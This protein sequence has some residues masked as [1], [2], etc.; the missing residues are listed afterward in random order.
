MN[1]GRCTLTIILITTFCPVT[2][3][4]ADPQSKPTDDRPV[5]RVATAEEFVQ[6]LGPERVIL[7]QP[8]E[9]NLSKV[10]RAK[11][12]HVRWTSPID[13][14]YQVE[15]RNVPGL[16]IRG[17]GQEPTHVFVHDPYAFV[18]TFRN[19]PRL[20]L[21]NLRMGHSPDAG[22]C[23]GGVVQ[24]L[25]TE[26]VRIGQCSLYGSGTEGLHLERVKALTFARSVIEDCTYGILTADDSDVLSFVDS[27]F[28]NVGQ[29]YGFEFQDCKGVSFRNCKIV[30]NVL[31][32]VALFK[33]NL[34][35][36]DGVI[37]LSGGEISRNAAARLVNEEGMLR[38]KDA[39]ISDNSWQAAA[40]V[41]KLRGTKV[42]REG[43]W[44]YYVNLGDATVEDVARRVYEFH[45]AEDV[46]NAVARLV[47]ANPKLPKLLHPGTEII[48]PKG[49]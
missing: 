7:L 17:A 1:L 24:V 45:S 41:V 13:G 28:R 19:A 49:K 26:Q 29:Y 43:G 36:S 42:P 14:Q 48:V 39:R 12:K 22:F 10:K 34:Q 40:N 44:A 47:R 46:Q 4:A 38:V 8:G 11:L 21:T 25:E 35:S 32:N 5:I 27:I 33:T 31:G 15:I 30:D 2:S 37:D 6:A 3:S 20:E 9:Y 23:L 16:S 18:L